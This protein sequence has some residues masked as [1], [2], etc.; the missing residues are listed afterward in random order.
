MHLNNKLMSGKSKG[1]LITSPKIA[2]GS[3]SSCPAARGPCPA[4]GGHGPQQPATGH[5][6][7]CT[8]GSRRSQYT[9]GHGGCAGSGAR[10]GCS[11][12]S[13]QCGGA[14]RV[15]PCC[16]RRRA[17][18]LLVPQGRGARLLYHVPG[19]A[20]P[21]ELPAVGQPHSSRGHVV[22][23]VCAGGCAYLH[24]CPARQQARCG[25][26]GHGG[27]G[28]L[29]VETGRSPQP[30]PS[31]AAGARLPTGSPGR[32]RRRVGTGVQLGAVRAL[33]PRSGARTSSDGRCPRRRAP[34]PWGCS[35]PAW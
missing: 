4:Q 16:R 6:G 9:R 11:V 12:G 7:P 28:G 20:M 34:S 18:C 15:L 3:C 2:I 10:A 22:M 13:A 14:G 21:A 27:W 23:G 29:W 31:G 8:A 33:R 26:L 30:W 1:I 24:P 35:R 25:C 32:A 5:Q 17:D 19:K